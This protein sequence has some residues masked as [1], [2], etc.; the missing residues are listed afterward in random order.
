MKSITNYAVTLTYLDPLL[1]ITTLRTNEKNNIFIKSVRDLQ[2]IIKPKND[3][4]GV[5][6]HIIFGFY[7]DHFFLGFPYKAILSTKILWFV[8]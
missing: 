1:S 4:A 3:A 6:R 7:M 5:A 2:E 8:S